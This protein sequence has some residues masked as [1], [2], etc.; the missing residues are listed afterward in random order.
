MKHW[1]IDQWKIDSRVGYI[2]CEKT[3]FNYIKIYQLSPQLIDFCKISYK[4]LCDLDRVLPRYSLANIK[5]P[6]IVSELPNPDNLEY[7]L[8]D[9]RHRIDKLIQNGKNSAFFYIIPSE[10]VL[11]FTIWQGP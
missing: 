6:M 5:Y 8:I 4:K 11:N 9:G 1:F 3:L 7:R 2:D 10:T